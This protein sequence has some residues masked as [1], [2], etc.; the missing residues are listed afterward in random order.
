MQ[1]QTIA[2]SLVVHISL[3]EFNT[4]KGQDFLRLAVRAADSQ[5]SQIDFL[6]P[7]V[8]PLTASPELICWLW[9]TYY[10]QS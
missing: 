8:S 9:Q 6:G 4:L 10:S 3:E 1:L 2:N 7:D 5:L